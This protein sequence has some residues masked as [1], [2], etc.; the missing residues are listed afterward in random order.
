MSFGDLVNEPEAELGETDLV[1]SLLRELGVMHVVASL[2]MHIWP[3]VSLIVYS[4]GV[5]PNIAE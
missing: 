3:L 5:A 1:A 2:L 4:P